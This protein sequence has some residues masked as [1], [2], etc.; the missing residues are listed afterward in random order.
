VGRWDVVEWIYVDHSD[1]NHT[2]DAEQA[3]GAQLILEIRADNRFMYIL[4]N[5]GGASY[6]AHLAGD[7]LVLTSST[8]S[9][10]YRVQLSGDDLTL[11]G[12]YQFVF[13]MDGDGTITDR[14]GNIE[15]VHDSIAA[16]RL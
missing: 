8:G 7:T 9:P 2:V 14:N 1:A 12:L 13:D 15:F 5:G 10:R 3:L 6:D 16:R 4:S 11:T